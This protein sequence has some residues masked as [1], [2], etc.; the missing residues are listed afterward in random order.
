M[1]KTILKYGSIV[2]LIG[3]GMISIFSIILGVAG[4]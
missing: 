1:I 3:F 2:I 4:I